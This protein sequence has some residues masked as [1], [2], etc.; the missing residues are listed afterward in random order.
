MGWRRFFR[1]CG[2]LDIREFEEKR[3]VRLFWSGF[4]G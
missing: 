3:G 1:G 4:D 2:C